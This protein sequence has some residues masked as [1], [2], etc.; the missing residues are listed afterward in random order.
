MTLLQEFGVQWG[1]KTEGERIPGVYGFIM[2]HEGELWVWTHTYSPNG[3][4]L[5]PIATGYDEVKAMIRMIG[6]RG[7]R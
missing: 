2:E 5:F 3:H 6:L 7:E 1:L 4:E